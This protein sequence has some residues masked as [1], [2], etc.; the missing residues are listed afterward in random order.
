[1]SIVTYAKITDPRVKALTEAIWK[2]SDG[3]TVENG[4]ILTAL[5]AVIAHAILR[6][7]Q[8]ARKRLHVLVGAAVSGDASALMTLLKRS[9]IEFI[10]TS[11]EPKAIQ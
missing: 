11:P 4:V 1:M 10:T 9:H 7:P 2:A 8:E 6:A 3:N 5:V